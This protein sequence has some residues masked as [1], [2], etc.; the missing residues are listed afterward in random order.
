MTL[1]F[2]TTVVYGITLG[3]ALAWA[4]ALTYRAYL[5]LPFAFSLSGIPE[6][7]AEWIAWLG[8]AAGIAALAFLRHRRTHP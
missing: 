2:L 5:G 1:R 8:A 4:V 6:A 3:S 7:T